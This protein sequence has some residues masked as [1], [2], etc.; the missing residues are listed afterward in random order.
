MKVGVWPEWAP[1]TPLR[2]ALEVEAV[3]R[4]RVIS[5]WEGG[6]QSGRNIRRRPPQHAGLWGIR[7]G[8]FYKGV[9]DTP[10]G[11]HLLPCAVDKPP[12]TVATSEATAGLLDQAD[13]DTELM[14]FPAGC[15][16]DVFLFGL[17]PRRW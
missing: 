6:G 7:R 4:G 11:L 16:R 13:P 1:H 14:I 3:S 2:G 12:R 9:G 17:G 10:G 5:I 15:G 8:P